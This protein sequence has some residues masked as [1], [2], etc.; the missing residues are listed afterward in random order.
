L[1]RSSFFPDIVAA[2]NDTVRNTLAV[3]QGWRADTVDRW[4]FISQGTT[5]IPYEWFLAL[6]QP[7]QKEPIR[8]PGNLQRLGFLNEP[9]GPYNPDGLPVGLYKWSVNLD[10]GKYKCGKGNWLG[11]GC[12][13]CHTGQ[14]NYHGQQIR[15]EGGPSHI[16]ITN[17]VGQLKLSLATIA[18]DPQALKSFIERVRATGNIVKQWIARS[19]ENA[20]LA[21]TV[22]CGRPDRFRAPLAYRARPLNG[23][24]AMAPYLHNGSVPSLYD[25]LLPP[26]QRPK[27]FYVGSWE[28]DPEIVGYETKKPLPDASLTLTGMDPGV[29]TGMDPPHVTRPV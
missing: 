23:I 20:A 2:Q 25:L 6:D 28:F 26:D 13:A 8:S 1:Q 12:A 11:L 22:N 10:Y 18:S 29:L 24:W 5:L 19:P 16:D 21:D 27:T 9:S 4:H 3:P 15:I 7:D 14:V 17:F